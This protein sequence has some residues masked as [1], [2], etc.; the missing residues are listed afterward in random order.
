MLYTKQI[1]QHIIKQHVAKMYRHHKI[2]F[3][4]K[5]KTPKAAQEDDGIIMLRYNNRT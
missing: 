5:E 4:L 2:T 3:V 1:M